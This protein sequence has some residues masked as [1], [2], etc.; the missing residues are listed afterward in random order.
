V[1]RRLR[2]VLLASTALSLTAALPAAAQ[3][4]TWLANPGS[5]N[6]NTGTNWSTG[7]V[8]TG[9]ASFGASSTTNLTIP[10]SVSLGGLTFNAGASAYAVA[11]DSNLVLTGAGIVIN[12]GSASFA[13]TNRFGVRLRFLGS[14]AAGTAIIANASTFGAIDFY[15]SSTAD[16]ATIN[17]GN[18]NNLFF[19]NTSTGG[20]A[21]ITN[22]GIISLNDSA[23]AGSATI[24]N[25]GTIFV[26]DSASAGSAII[27]TSGG[28]LDFRNTSTAANASITVDGGDANF[29]DTS[30]A[31]NATLNIAA[32]N[33]NFRVASTAGSSSITI[34]SAGGIS[35]WDTAAAGSASITNNGIVTFFDSST[36]GSATITTNN[37]G[38]AIFQDSS[39]GGNAR[40]VTN[41]GGTF[42][43]STLTTSGM[44]AGSIEGAGNYILGARALTVGSN[45]LS[46]EVSGVISGT[47]GSLIKTG[48]GTLI[49]SGANTY[50]GGTTVDNGT[51]Q[52]GTAS[53]MGSI[54]GAVTVNA[55]NTLNLV[56]TDTSG[57][58]GITTAGFTIFRE[59]MS[60]GSLG[61]TT[62]GNGQVAF[63]GGNSAQSATLINNGTFS[64][65]S[66]SG[67][68]TAGNATITQNSGSMRFF[69]TSTAGNATIALVNGNTIFLQA[70]TAGGA[71]ITIGS[72]ASASFTG[73]ST[74]GNAT[75]VSNG[76]LAFSNN[77]TAGNA[78]IS[79]SGALNFRNTS[80]GG[81]AS[82][83]NSGTINLY[84]TSTAGSATIANSSNLIFN[85]NST[86]GGATI[87]NVSGGSVQFADTATA[88]NATIIN[89]GSVDFNAT[90]TAGNAIITNNIG[91]FLT[92]TS[93]SMAGSANITN[94][95][96]L[97]F[98]GSST[99]GSAIITN[100]GAMGFNFSSTAGSATIANNSTLNFSNTSTAGNATITTNTGGT[101]AFLNS[102]TG[103][104][105]RFITN[106]GG[107]FNIS[108]LGA[109]G[110]TAGSIE[111]AGSYNLGAKELTAGSNNRSTEV[112][113]TLSGTGGSLIKTGA[114]TLTL[115]GTNSYTGA[116]TVNGGTLAVNSSLTATSGITINNG[117]ALGGT[118]TVG[119]TTIASGGALAPG[120]SIGTLNVSGNLT[121]NAGGF[122]TVEV[123]PTAADRT[124]VTGTATLTGGTVQAAITAPRSY[125]TQA[126]TILN[127]TGG[128]GGTQFASLTITGSSTDRNPH[129]D[130]GTN[131]VSL[132]LDPSRLVP[133][134]GAS[135]NQAGVAG[136]INKA[137]A[138]GSTPGASF[139]GLL[140]MSGARLNQAFDQLSGQPATGAAISGTQMTTSFLR[141]LLDPDGGAVGSDKFGGA[142]SFASQPALSPEVAAAYAAVT[143][144]DKGLAVFAE[145]RWS[146]WGQVFGGSNRTG[147]DT[148][149]TSVRTWGLS[150][151]FDY[152][153]APD[154]TLGFALAGGST[155]WGLSQGLGGGRSEVMQLGAYGRK[156]L[157]PAYLAAAFSYAWHSMSTDRTVTVSGTDKLAAS[158]DA[159]GFGGRIEAGYRFAK[160]WMG[161]TPYAALQMQ[162]FRTPSYG[163]SAASGSNAFAL[164]YDA[165]ST[166]ATRTELGTWFDNIIALDRGN[167]LA[168]R[169]RAAWTYDHSSN[170][171]MVAVFQTLP[172]SN[173]T[174]NG[175]QA[176]PNS[177]LTSLGAELRLANR[178]SVG[179][180]FDGEFANGSQT[181]AGIGR[182]RYAW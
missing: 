91:S 28:S 59:G 161:V 118:G 15:D 22:N 92:F 21:N 7:A 20:S 52:L 147:G 155:N 133:S 50:T 125:R 88:G 75:I 162:N 173:F 102:G 164:A 178:W 105:A 109:S 77:G 17:N 135:G 41:A 14:S 148:A 159:H 64:V 131:S 138:N 66:F 34:T 83:T 26:N 39:T 43:I 61:I 36:A 123:S 165:R 167:T 143:P 153:A 144:R 174:V 49:L 10:N 32:R 3:N 168:L 48:S 47:G 139:D 101:T 116:T 89:S 150:T 142:R 6:F 5:G 176:A 80:T 29:Y 16:R 31:G 1:A 120:N 54:V 73:S 67:D 70:T 8:P 11:I 4:A 62:T 114:G 44:T 111:G 46:T 113:G 72:N 38:N 18:G 132:V 149:D 170:Q 100:N 112:S 169:S 151:G 103:G 57:I 180:R 25:S 122:Y 87:T 19:F 134:P 175:A 145:P 107:I 81:G 86:A 154:L 68:S 110:M 71:S 121:F 126:F 60:A 35:F 136:G 129:L 140:G 76:T 84:D 97:S 37:G 117:G 115:S 30:T 124:N 152:R 98:L 78:T 160:P 55:N 51:L 166:T 69:G 163:E 130:Y 119:N 104:D 179:A 177:L 146:V 24:A 156:E 12:G 181:Y 90:S 108:G 137:V 182:I 95:G 82:I 27:T 56:N 128:L 171:T 63:F 99:A 23:S 9:T 158:F 93:T 96:S 172:G 79:N 40:F 94:N 58:T 33:L 157:G 127:A 42:D 53:S 13:T 141:L 74:A 85:S 65:I 2:V 106:T 45:N